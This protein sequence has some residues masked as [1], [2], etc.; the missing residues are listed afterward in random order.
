VAKQPVKKQP[1]GK[2]SLK[3]K[4]NPQQFVGLLVLIGIVGV[5]TLGYVLTRPAGRA[6]TVDP[7]I[8]AGTA[9]GYLMGNKEAPVQVIEFGDFECP[10][11][12]DFATVTEPDV[13]ERLVKTGIVSFRFFDFPLSGH[14]NTWTAHVAASC[15]SEQGKFWEMHDR[16]FAGQAEWNGEA[17]NA[18][19][20]VMR[21]FAAELPLDVAK[22]DKCMETQ[23]Y[24]PRIKANAAEG[25]RRQI[26]GTPTFII[27]NKMLPAGPIAYDNFKR[28]VD[29]A[30]A[31]LPKTD[32]AGKG[33]KPPAS[34]KGATR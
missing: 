26:T 11:C 14:R 15:A 9:E 21:R 8:P 24:V 32:S 13:R 5:A 23:P 33:A 16:I 28:A 6:I 20:K 25:Q 30:L 18:P 10:G 27:G 12:G 29:E 7:N 17:T 4:G 3:K 19:Q 31:A 34:K 2:A 22:W 1:A